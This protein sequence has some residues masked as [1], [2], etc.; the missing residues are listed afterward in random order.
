MVQ[1]LVKIT[2]ETNRVL[3]SVKAI[4]GLKDKSEAI[5]FIVERFSE[6]SSNP[7]LKKT[8]LDEIK[9]SQK[10]KSIKVHSFANRYGL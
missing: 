9:K 3:N 6:N 4:H 8:F 10:E 2:S 7:Q 1:A 5:E